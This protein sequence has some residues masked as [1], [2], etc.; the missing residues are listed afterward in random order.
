MEIG[1]NFPPEYSKEIV[2]AYLR[3]RFIYSLAGLGLG[4]ICIVGGT[5]LLLNA[6]AGT[7]TWTASLLG[8]ETKLNDAAPGVVLFVVGIFLVLITRHKVQITFNSNGVPQVLCK[9]GRAARLRKSG[10]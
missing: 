1:H 2:T 8:F 10:N 3:H 7:T 9:D 6:V 4:L 5:A